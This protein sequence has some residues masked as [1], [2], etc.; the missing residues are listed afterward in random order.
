[1]KQLDG[2][3]GAESGFFQGEWVKGWIV[4][5]FV[6]FRINVNRNGEIGLIVE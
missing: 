3:C 1:M 6:G 5:W 4:E 2:L